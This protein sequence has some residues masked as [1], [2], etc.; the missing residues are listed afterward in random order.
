MKTVGHWPWPSRY[1]LQE[2]ALSWISAMAVFCPLTT[3][4]AAPIPHISDEVG[5][6]NS[7]SRNQ[8]D[9]LD[10]PWLIEANSA[11]AVV[12]T[13]NQIVSG[14]GATI[15][16]DNYEL[17]TTASGIVTTASLY[18]FTN[19]DLINPNGVGTAITGNAELANSTTLQGDAPRP[20]SFYNTAAQPRFFNENIGANT[21]RNAVL[22]EFS[23]P[24]TAFG[25]WFGDLETNPNGTSAIVRLLDADGNR[26]GD[27]IVIPPTVDPSLCGSATFRGCGNRTTRWI[28]FVD[29]ATQV[30]QM[31]VVVGDDAPGDTGNREHISFIGAT[32]AEK[33]QADIAVTK[34]HSGGPFKPGDTVTYI[35]TVT[36]QGPTDAV[37]IPLLDFVPSELSNVLWSCQ[38]STPSGGLDD[39]QTSAGSGNTINTRLSLGAGGVATFT[40]TGTLLPTPPGMVTSTVEVGNRDR[41]EAAPGITDPDLSNNIVS[42]D[43]TVTSA[44]SGPP[45]ICDGTFLIAQDANSRYFAADTGNN[46]LLPLSTFLGSNFPDPISTYMNGIGFNVQDG[47]IYGVNPDNGN[48]YRLAADGTVTNLGNPG[49]VPN[50]IFSGDVDG[51]GIFYAQSGRWI[52]K[53]NVSGATA[54]VIGSV[55]LSRR[56]K[57][58]DVAFN[59]VNGLLYGFDK[60]NDVVVEINPT[61][62]QVT[63]LSTQYAPG[64][65]SITQAGASY[66]DVF[67][68]FYAYQN[69]PGRLLK[70]SLDLTNNIALGAD[71]AT[72]RNVVKNDGAACPYSPLIQ[73][74]IS[75]TTVEAGETVTYTYKI[76][77]QN[78]F[79]LG[80]VS[81]RDILPSTD[82]RTYV[83]GSLVNPLDGIVN[84]Y[85]NSQQLEITG[86]TVPSN[87]TVEFS[88]QVLIPA[89]TPPGEVFNQ[90]ELEN[91]PIGFGGPR[92]LSDYPPT[93]ARPDPTPLTV[94]VPLANT[95]NLL[96]VKRI[97]RI[98]G[99]T[100]TA[101]GADLSLYLDEANSPYDDNDISVTDPAQPPDTDQWPDPTVN[102]L[103]H[104]DGGNVTPNDEIEYTIY[105]LSS[106]DTT[107]KNVLFCDYVPTFTSF[108][109][110]AYTGRGPQALGGIG[111]A[112]L[113]IE[114][115]RNGTTHYHT[116]ANDGDSATYFSPGVDPANSFPG[117]D[118]DGDGD[119]VN[120]NTNGAVVV[121]L[122][123][124]SDATTNITAAYGY[125]RFST[126]VK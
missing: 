32:L 39:C 126:Q 29:D 71:Y 118:C 109:D 56:V 37:D 22:F 10:T 6:N 47:Y 50:K 51:S 90:A 92:L 33:L 123:D 99:N 116:G 5:Y 67:G 30:K 3:A 44:A 12:V 18:N 21:S 14:S 40:V 2:I 19:A 119:G 66:F 94:T 121:N 82:G 96:L 117:I 20:A 8:V 48:V 91:I 34:T 93:G 106:G 61:T 124:L 15:P 41:N 80:G 27:D 77:N 100:T 104:I 65:S 63:N 83:S 72:G 122:G 115:F 62:G 38:V 49:S 17:F 54:V 110:N 55:R 98:N 114:L 101:D 64:T 86:L 75:T 16:A 107:A 36:N 4:I 69:N 45:F 46:Q 26:I 68:D 113:S 35:M 9:L 23:E 60:D 89:D 105:F 76:G 79:P 125:V 42:D 13:Q 52:Y 25:A 24:V 97:T 108:I 81:F 11:G 102:L 70:F 58:D 85:G 84:A 103:G 95:P 88:I 112:D 87:Q 120:A 28:G 31:L 43:I 74:D 7:S 1:W 73:K 59:P 111:N 57:A 78:P 53:L